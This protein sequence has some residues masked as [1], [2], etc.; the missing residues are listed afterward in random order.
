MGI[1]G[2]GG[3]ASSDS[4]V[5]GNKGE[6]GVNGDEEMELRPQREGRRDALK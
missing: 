5:S 2:R 1:T 4:C 3:A 6:E